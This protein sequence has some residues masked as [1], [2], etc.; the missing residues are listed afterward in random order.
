MQ[1]GVNLKQLWPSRAQTPV[2]SWVWLSLGNV[3]VISD[4]GSAPLGKVPETFSVSVS[5][6]DISQ[7][8]G[9]LCASHLVQSGAVRDA[10]RDPHHPWP[11]RWSQAGRAN[12]SRSCHTGQFSRAPLAANPHS[13]CPPLPRGPG[14]TL[15]R[16]E[17]R[18]GRQVPLRW[19]LG[20]AGRR[21]RPRGLAIASQGEDGLGADGTC[22]ARERVFLLFML[23]GGN[24]SQA[25]RMAL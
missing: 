15:R 5:M 19:G 23:S 12:P 11:S 25:F 4:S 21:G 24:A 9:G 8:P 20:A 2:P 18:A 14:S 6:K 7:D 13:S 1:W 10:P 22:S 16:G 17:L 3:C